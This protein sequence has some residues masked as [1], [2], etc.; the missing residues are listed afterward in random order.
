MNKT[1]WQIPIPVDSA[2]LTFSGPANKR[3]YVKIKLCVPHGFRNVI[4]GEIMLSVSGKISLFLS[5]LFIDSI[6]ISLKE[7]E[8]KSKSIG[9][10]SWLNAYSTD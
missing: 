1:T 9:K 10:K 2:E 6:I 7:E 3:K 8:G 5:C 4:N